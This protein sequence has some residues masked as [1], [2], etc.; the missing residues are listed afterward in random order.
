[1]TWRAPAAGLTA[2]LRARMVAVHE[3]DREEWGV[4]GLVRFDPGADGRGTF[5]TLGPS[6]GRTASGLGQWFDYGPV[7]EEAG[8]G[9]GMAGSEPLALL[10]PYAGLSLAESGERALRL[11]AR[12]SHGEWVSLGVEATRASAEDS[13]MLRG[14]LSW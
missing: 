12:Y 6:H 9:F 4:S 14:A 7:T 2:E 8:H 1:M 11:G 10:T 3:R 5:L 13:V